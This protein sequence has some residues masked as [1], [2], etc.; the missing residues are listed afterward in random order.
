MLFGMYT[1]TLGETINN[2]IPGFKQTIQKI[3]KNS[4]IT[5]NGKKR[6]LQ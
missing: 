4:T 3:K 2:D 6:I 5:S 1:E